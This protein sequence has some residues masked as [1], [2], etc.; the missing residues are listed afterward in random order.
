MPVRA[1]DMQFASFR[2]FLTADIIAG[3]RRERHAPSFL[4]LIG[5]VKIAP[6]RTSRTLEVLIEAG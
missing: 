3:L 2:T 1:T 6:R 5:T 4:P